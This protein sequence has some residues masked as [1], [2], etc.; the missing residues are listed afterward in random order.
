[1]EGKLTY[2]E[3]QREIESRGIMPQ[4][5]P[6]LEPT[7]EG[8]RRMGF[9]RYPLAAR[10]RQ[11]PTRAIVVAGTNG[12]GSVCAAL[13]ALLIDAGERTGLFTS[14]HLMEVTER[15]RIAGEDIPE[16]LFCQ[17]YERVRDAVG[18]LT[19]SHFEWITLMAVWI[20]GSGE[21]VPPVDRLLLETGMGGQWDSTNAVPHG[22]AIIT[23]L[24]FDHE[25]FLGATLSEIARNKFGI[26]PSAE[27]LPALPGGALVVHAPLPEE[28][29]SVADL[30]RLRTQ[31]RWFTAE[32]GELEVRSTPKGPDFTLKT[33]WGEG[34]LALAGRR[35]AA[36]ACLALTAFEKLGFDPTKHLGA[37]NKIRWPGR[38]ER[39]ESALA[40]C[41]IYLSGDH[42]PQGLQSLRELLPLYRRRHLHI[43]VGVGNDKDLG[44]ILS[45][46]KGISESS[47][48]FTQ[49]PFK[50]LSIREYGKWLDLG[51]GAWESPR[52][53]L[54]SIAQNAQPD[55]LIL[56]TGSLYLVGHIRKFLVGSFQR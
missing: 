52:A 44:G 4:K 41:P 49:T 6:S 43:L 33:R 40:P 28:V 38:M 36:N 15:F 37:L 32:P 25:R 54:V 11:D 3:I 16:A 39:I 50:G 22:V 2:E 45:L 7:L 5:A 53:A 48:Y 17:A 8:L 47:L 30:T 34:P 35:G 31:S 14:P 26:V 46:L 24:G 18:D 56:V 29:M 19:L 10:I 9:D 23:S 13:E 21:A 12:K 20:F 1:L 55:D 51:R 42:N 27:N